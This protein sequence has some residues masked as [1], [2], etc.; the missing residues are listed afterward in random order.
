MS[1]GVGKL[2]I[3]TFPELQYC[4]LQLRC[5]PEHRFSVVFPK[6]VHGVK[7]LQLGLWEASSTA[8]LDMLRGLL[9]KFGHDLEAANKIS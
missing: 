9:G 5:V 3:G 1:G 8:E 6:A 4:K 7:A 2:L